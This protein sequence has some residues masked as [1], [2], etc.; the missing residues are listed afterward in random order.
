MCLGGMSD[1]VFYVLF[2]ESYKGLGLDE[3]M[4]QVLNTTL[5]LN[6]GTV[7]Q[8]VQDQLADADVLLEQHMITEQ[9]HAEQVALL[10]SQAQCAHVNK[11][12]SAIECQMC[13]GPHG[14]K[15]CLDY[16]THHQWVE[17]QQSSR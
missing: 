12:I 5:S 7:I 14:A 16:V 17:A 1:K 15:Q 3:Y 6:M 4:K 10:S 8:E 11:A 13:G 2:T 9:V